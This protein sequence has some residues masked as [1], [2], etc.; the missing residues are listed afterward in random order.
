[1]GDD[2]IN[3]RLA[4]LYGK[5][6]SCRLALQVPEQTA[7]VLSRSE[8]SAIGLTGR[9]FR[10]RAESLK[11]LADALSKAHD[12]SKSFEQIDEAV[13]I[14]EEVLQLWSSHEQ[15]YAG[16]VTDLG[17]ALN[18]LCAY[19]GEERPWVRG[20]RCIQLLRESLTLRPPGHPLRDQSLH[21][22]ARALTTVKY[23]ESSG[24]ISVYEESAGLTR[25]ALQLR[26]EGH[27]QRRDSL[28]NLGL[29][30]RALF[31]MKG[32]QNALEE[33]ILV[34]R[35][36][37][38]MHPPGDELR[39]NSLNLL[40]VGL[41]MWF[42]HC[43]D[44]DK[45]AEAIS[46]LRESLLLQPTGHHS[47][48][49]TLDNLARSILVGA[50]F[51]GRTEQ[52]HESIA[53]GR[54]AMQL[55]PD[56]HPEWGRIRANLAGFLM[57]AFRHGSAPSEV[58]SEAVDLYR[59]AMNFSR[60]RFRA[61]YDPMKG[62]AEA[63][64]ARYDLDRCY[65]DLVEALSL[66]RQ[67]LE[68][69]P[70]GA[71]QRSETMQ[72]LANM[73]CRTE[74]QSWSQAFSLF[75]E[76]LELC[77]PG[78]PNRAPLLSDMSKC[79]LA[80]LSPFFDFAEGIALIS[81][82]HTDQFCHVNV[83]LKSA[84][85]NLRRA[86][87]AYSAATGGLAAPD[88][89]NLT[90]RVLALYIEVI[91]ILPRVA[92]FGL[93]HHARLQAVTGSDEIVRNAAA[94]ALYIERIPHAVEILEEG[95]GVFWS[96]TLHLR[97]TGFNGVPEKD[98]RELERLLQELSFRTRRAQSSDMSVAQQEQDLETRRKLNDEAEALITT[99][100][101]YPG[102]ARFLMPAAFSDL[103]SALPDGY[104]VILNSSS[105]GHHALLLNGATGLAKSFELQAS[106]RDFDSE[107][108][109][110]QV[111]RN[112]LRE[113]NSEPLWEG[114]RAM[115]VSGRRLRSLDDTL[116]LLWDSIVR[117]VLIELG[118]TVRPARAVTG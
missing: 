50:M 10:V 5:I 79:Y 90:S 13:T 37:L 20:Q 65:D 45:L 18:N 11:A 66:N 83:R 116:A 38:A 22:L 106:Y 59:E 3:P 7:Y 49:R 109:R 61:I 70:N 4:E 35:Q 69:H 102:L 26:P 78:F 21:A 86:E 107:T 54:E 53:L 17:V 34:H 113:V 80:P 46:L 96:Q 74:C 84:V 118:I 112:V 33:M 44:I 111:D 9:P 94:R 89:Y 110:S 25:E 14:Y 93:D 41:R 36:A 68:L 63:L 103:I 19:R 64:T 76:A 30:L 27:P 95:R 85:S 91:G 52:F 104:I 60:L 57:D 62:L 77:P 56:D 117:P 24:S 39:Y 23:G 115:K 98:C 92:N 81:E 58:V 51:Q 47:R 28:V 99:I 97:T 15:P 43:G 12:V 55:M 32:D 42:E 82:A 72:K 8:G 87:E 48:Y 29:D 101:G 16:A 2:S 40:A 71:W 1:M 73:L 31:M 100:R 6:R 75:R 67:S 105:L 114:T 88:D 108:I